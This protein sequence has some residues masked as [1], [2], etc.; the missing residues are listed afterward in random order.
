MDKKAYIALGAIV[1]LGAGAYFASSGGAL[2]GSMNAGPCDI[3]PK[4][5]SS[6]VSWVPSRVVSSRTSNVTSRGPSMTTS[7][8]LSK[9]VVQV[10]CPGY[11]AEMKKFVHPS[12]PVQR[13]G[14]K[15]PVLVPQK[16]RGVQN[17]K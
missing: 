11:W 16:V 7:K 10:P 3:T 6:V 17:G 2:K 1:I 4:G 15:A 14:D 9:T 12:V 8:V 13:L 5:T